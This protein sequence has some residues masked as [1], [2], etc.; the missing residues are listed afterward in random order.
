MLLM[1]AVQQRGAE[2]IEIAPSGNGH[3]P[4]QTHLIA[5]KTAPGLAKSYLAQKFTWIVF[6]VFPDHLQAQ[7]I[8]SLQST[9]SAA[10]IFLQRMNI[11]V[12]KEPDHIIALLAQILHRV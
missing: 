12:I 3:G 4:F 7:M 6:V 2:K 11:W 8:G 9:L 10:E 5:K 1:D